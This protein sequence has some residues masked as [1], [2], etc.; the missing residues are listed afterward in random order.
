MLRLDGICKSYS[1]GGTEVRAL[2]GLSLGFRSHEFVAVLGPSGCGKTTLLNIIGGLDRYDSGDLKINGR[3]T[4]DYSDADWDSYRNHSVGF[5]FQSY[6][7]IPHQSVLSN[8]E[9]ALTLSG[10]GKSERRARARAVLERVGLGDQLGKRPNQLSGGQMQRVAIA[11]AL[12]NDPDILLAD[13]PTGALDTETSVQIMEILK[14]ISGEK[15]VIMV[16][17]NPELAERYATRTVRLLDGGIISDS[18]PFSPEDEPAPE[19][20]GK[21]KRPSMS[22]ASALSLSFNNLLTKKGRTVLTAFAGSIGIIGIALILSLSNGIQNYINRVQEDTLSSYPIVIEGETYDTAA[23][24]QT[25]AG[26]SDS[27]RDGKSDEEL[28]QY[29]YSDAVM[30]ELYNAATSLEANENDLGAFKAFL[31]TPD[32]EG[33]LPLDGYAS[34]VSYDYGLTP[35]LYV[36]HADGSVGRPDLAALM[37]SAGAYSGGYGA[38][39][40]EYMNSFSRF[41]VWEEMLPGR[42]SLVS[43]LLDEQYDVLFGRWPEAYDEVV[44]IVGPNNQ[45]S[46]LVLYELGLMSEEEMT[47]FIKKM[48]SFESMDTPTEKWSF[49]EICS[50]PLKM[51]L[52]ADRWKEAP[53]GGYTDLSANELGERAMYDAGTPLKICGIVRPGNRSVSSMLSGSIGY[54]VALSEFISETAAS[55]PVVRDQLARPDFDVLAGLPFASAADISDEAI[56]A[57]VTEYAASLSE[58]EKASL[59]RELVMRPDEDTVEMLLD[60]Y[61]LGVDRGAAQQSIAAQFPEY[62]AMLDGMDDETLF[63]YIREGM[64]SQIEEECRSAAARQLASFSDPEL[65]A[66][67]DADLPNAGTCAVIYGEFMPDAVSD[68]TYEENLRLLGYADPDKPLRISIYSSTFA[69]KDGVTD[70]IARYNDAADEDQKLDYTDYVGLLMSSVTTILKAIS[71]VLVA[72]VSISLVVSSIMIGIITYISVLERTKEIGILRSIGASRRD[73]ARVFN[74]ETLIVGLAAG[75]MGILVTVLLNI[76]ITLLVRRLTG[77]PYLTSLLPAF[78]G[79]VLVAISMLLTLVAGLIPSRIASG[80][81]PVVALRSE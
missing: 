54:T 44:L 58:A 66:M 16:T 36:S 60:Q 49:E 35:E 77:I 5:V 81:D 28:G 27:A 59:Y 69:G 42:D 30:Y 34:A 3:S 12:V 6:N 52:P 62:A 47:D 19:S 18:A 20:E 46:D 76:P 73:I 26:V 33:A 74:A 14:E 37:S 38:V 71:Y 48:S 72:F 67:L 24:L 41:S 15:L 65:A 55:R 45:L 63:S 17:H 64:R 57:A 13:E 39:R 53:D 29:V 22:L 68:S 70:V 8:V 10:V 4:G 23:L 80:K 61:M 32:S 51:V 7:L 9:L 31:E 25:M 56:T 75:L 79:A 11:R 1:A 50:M 2:R 78:S 40:P 43:P 21:A